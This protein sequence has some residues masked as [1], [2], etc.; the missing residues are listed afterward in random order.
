MVIIPVEPDEEINGMFPNPGTFTPLAS[1]IHTA[2]IYGSNAFRDNT[3]VGTNWKVKQVHDS[4]MIDLMTYNDPPCCGGLAFRTGSAVNTAL[5][6]LNNYLTNN[7]NDLPELISFNNEE[8]NFGYWE[9]TA[10]D[11]LN[12][13]NAATIVA[14]NHGIPVS[15]GGI[16]HNFFWYMRYVYQQEGKTDSVNYINNIMG[17]GPSTPAFAQVVIDWYKIEIPGLAASDIDY[18]NFHN[19]YDGATPQEMNLVNLTIRFLG[20]RTGKPV[21]TTEAGTRNA[22]QGEFNEYFNRINQEGVKIRVYYNG[23]G[24]LAEEHPDWWLAWILQ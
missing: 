14:H 17:I 8:P 13:L 7:P 16:L 3:D 20:S 2:K 1:R 23:T 12:W 22:S 18:V 21:I 24:P 6:T 9:G 10:N 19:Y 4:G 15:N 11:Y 5:T